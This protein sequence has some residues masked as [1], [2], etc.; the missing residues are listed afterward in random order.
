MLVTWNHRSSKSRLVNPCVT[1]SNQGKRGLSFLLS[2]LHAMKTSNINLFT[3]LLEKKKKQPQMTPN[4]FNSQLWS[5][6]WLIVFFCCSLIIDSK[7]DTLTD[8]SVAYVFKK[9]IP[10]TVMYDQ[11]LYFK[12]KNLLKANS[13]LF[14]YA[15]SAKS[16]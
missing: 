5:A 13:H 16:L 15:P 1:K 7:T 4:Q 12:E 9:N 6:D 8:I 11:F 3:I 2:I 14:Q 10:N